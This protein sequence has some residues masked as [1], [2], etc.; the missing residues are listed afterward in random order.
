M[1]KEGDAGRLKRALEHTDGLTPV[2]IAEFP[3]RT[4]PSP[5]P[6][7]IPPDTLV[8]RFSCIQDIIEPGLPRRSR[9]SEWVKSMKP[10]YVY[11]PADGVR[12]TNGHTEWLFKFYPLSD[13]IKNIKDRKAAALKFLRTGKRGEKHPRLDPEPSIAKCGDIELETGLL[14]DGE[15]ME[16]LGMG[17][18]CQ[19]PHLIAGLVASYL[20]HPVRGGPP[21]GRPGGGGRK[22][23]RKKT[24]RKSH[25]KKR[26]KT[27]R[28]SHKKKRT[29]RKK[30]IKR[31]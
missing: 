12:Q 23:T 3:P 13:E 19:Q 8:A 31:K 20:G 17:G 28:R 24:R 10:D 16:G 29:T 6:D 15:G 7:N 9:I 25:K 27:R 30:K 26:K 11:F 18:V 22:K 21:R 4:I 1:K 5:H 2:H 14:R